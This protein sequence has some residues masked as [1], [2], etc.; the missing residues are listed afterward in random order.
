M[1]AAVVVSPAAQ[2]AVQGVATAAL[3]VAAHLLFT[4]NNRSR[5]VLEELS[6]GDGADVTPAQ[7]APRSGSAEVPKDTI[8]PSPPKPQ[9]RPAAS[10]SASSCASTSAADVTLRHTAETRPHPLSS[11]FDAA[12]LSE[13]VEVEK[14]GTAQVAGQAVGRCVGRGLSQLFK[15]RKS[16]KDET[17][18]EAPTD[19]RQRVEQRA[20]STS[21]AVSAPVAAAPPSLSPVANSPSSPGCTSASSPRNVSTRASPAASTRGV[22]Q[23]SGQR[24][25]GVLRSTAAPATRSSVSTQAMSGAG[26][27]G[28]TAPEPEA[29]ASATASAPSQEYRREVLKRLARR[30][31]DT[32]VAAGR[33]PRSLHFGKAGLQVLDLAAA[34]DLA[35]VAR[36]A[37][38]DEAELPDWWTALCAAHGFS[39]EG[40]ELVAELPAWVLQRSA[41]MA[42]LLRRTHWL[43][44]PLDHAQAEL[45]SLQQ[46]L[47]LEQP[48]AD[49]HPQE[50]ASRPLRQQWPQRLLN[51]GTQNCQ[52]IFHGH[53]SKPDDRPACLEAKLKKLLAFFESE[54]LDAVCLQETWVPEHLVGFAREVAEQMGWWSAWIPA[55]VQ[56][57]NKVPSAG[58]AVLVRSRLVRR[59]AVSSACPFP[60]ADTEGRFL[61]MTFRWGRHTIDLAS[62]YLPSADQGRQTAF[63]EH[64]LAP[65]CERRRRGRKVVVMGDFN[66]VAEPSQDATSPRPKDAKPAQ[67]MADKCSSLLDAHRKR[68]PKSLDFTHTS[69]VGKSQAR[70]DRCYVDAR[71]LRHIKASEVRGRGPSGEEPLT[72]H[73]L[74]VTTLAS[75]GP[76]PLLPRLRALALAAPRLRRRGKPVKLGGSGS[77][78]ATMNNRKR[79]GSSGRLAEGA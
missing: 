23:A 78:E 20:L 63:I 32:R 62:V 24:P 56:P 8:T 76:M 71:L 57:G 31:V 28:A 47:A 19:Y 30:L 50:P 75:D 17:R 13:A 72:D 1:I 25:A 5:A 16:V 51:I 15:T 42:R 41:R 21:A 70:L 7:P 45:E 43:G 49:A 36:E 64:V 60:T 46:E 58:V 59:G 38:V 67:A 66:F 73:A 10:T 48:T 69:K 22:P 77:S 27:G 79:A 44:A 3:A 74:V 26:S 9:Q 68:Y 14:A 2:A 33:P 53:N 35:A 37:G 11:D 4:D 52:G 6:A 54:Q 40:D 18:A 34:E 39:V 12:V 61:G 29:P 65:F 55:E